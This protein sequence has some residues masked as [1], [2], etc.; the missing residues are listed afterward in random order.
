MFSSDFT[1]LY[2]FYCCFLCKKRTLMKQ[3][4]NRFVFWASIARSLSFRRNP[5][6]LNKL[7]AQ[8]QNLCFCSNYFESPG[9]WIWGFKSGCFGLVSGV[10]LLLRSGVP[11]GLLGFGPGLIALIVFIL[12]YLGLSIEFKKTRKNIFTENHKIAKF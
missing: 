11:S 12:K 4:S 6:L 5:K 8:I 10:T 9:L 1:E 7:K 3:R 2:R